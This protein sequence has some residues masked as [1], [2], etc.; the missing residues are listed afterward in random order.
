MVLR[1]RTKFVKSIK[2]KRCPKCGT[3]VNRR[4]RCKV[5]HRKLKVG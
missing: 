2:S 4:K 1:P 3:L 5:C